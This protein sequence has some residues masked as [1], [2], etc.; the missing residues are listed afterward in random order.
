[1]KDTAAS[2][3]GP[4]PRNTPKHR[5]SPPSGG[6]HPHSQVGGTDASASARK[7]IA[8]AVRWSVQEAKYSGT[9][10]R[11][12]PTLWPPARFLIVGTPL[13]RMERSVPNWLSR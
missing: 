7:R 1:M 11:F 3:E 6:R 9:S 5:K 13:A 10:W 4:G 2:A 12:T 8:D